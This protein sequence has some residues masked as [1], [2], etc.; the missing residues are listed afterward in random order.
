[1]TDF[2]LDN[3]LKNHKSKK[4]PSLLPYLK[5]ESLKNYNL[6][7]D[8]NSLEKDKTYIKYIRKANAF[9]N[10]RYSE[11]VIYD[12]GL[13]IAGGYFLNGKFVK[14]DNKNEWEYLKLDTRIS[15]KTR[16]PQERFY[17][18]YI[19]IFNY[20]IFYKRIGTNN[21]LRD[22]LEAILVTLV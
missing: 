7:N 13:L 21:S 22:N 8:V 11:N 20:Y 2:N 6:L 5:F 4:I 9:E 12:G 3:F 17:S 18:Y 16:L 10:N 19:R 15:K 1:M 14:T